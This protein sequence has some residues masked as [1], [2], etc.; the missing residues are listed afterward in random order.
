MAPAK[1]TRNIHIDAPVA[2]V[3][4]YLEDPAHFVGGIPAKAHATLGAG[5]WTPEGVVT[6][7]EVKFRELGM[8][9]TAVF[10][11]EEY[12]VNQRIVDHSS[13]GP[14]FTLSVEPD[15]SGTT[16]TTNWD[17]STLDKMLDA[18]WFHGD[19]L[20]EDEFATIKHEVESLA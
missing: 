14:V 12:K 4:H 20:I 11:R 1:H 6:D 9:F 8:H 5:E 16:L 2:K 3:F 19:K 13:Q 15:A 7:Y 17:S 18:I 10:T